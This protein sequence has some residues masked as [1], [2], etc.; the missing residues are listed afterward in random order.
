MIFTGGGYEHTLHIFND[1]KKIKTVN[2]GKNIYD[3]V[4]MN[5]NIYVA[6]EDKVY[7]IS[8]SNWNI[9]HKI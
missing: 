8:L 1:Q 4:V 6:G 2:F 9:I 3:C 7:V 5:G